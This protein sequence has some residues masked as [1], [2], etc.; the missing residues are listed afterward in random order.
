MNYSTYNLINIK[1]KYFG[2]LDYNEKIQDIRIM[3]V[4]EY[5]KD[6]YEAIEKTESI[7]IA[8]QIFDSYINEL[9]ELK[10]KIKGKKVGNLYK[11]LMGWMFNSNGFEGAVLKGW[12]ESRFGIIPNFHKTR[13]DHIESEGYYNYLSE[14]MSQ[15]VNKNAIYLQLDLLY[16]YTQ[17]VIKRFFSSFKPRVTLYRGVYNLEENEII[18]WL[19]K[20]A[21]VMSHNNVLSFTVDKSIAEQFGDSILKINVPYT[22]IIFFSEV[23]PLHHFAG[24][25]EFIVIGGEYLTEI[26]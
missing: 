22:K 10:C 12:A 5:H 16:H 2:S 14:K 21:A 24:E 18:T 23:T 7:L 6:F 9:F 13:I 20:N 4:Y 25:Q 8:N 15:R 1:S 19:S 11:I 17:V 26:I 3:G